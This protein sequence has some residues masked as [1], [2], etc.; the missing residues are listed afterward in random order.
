MSVFI[1]LGLIFA[2]YRQ[3]LERKKQE[4]ALLAE[5]A[6]NADKAGE[7]AGNITVKATAKGLQAATVTI[8][9]K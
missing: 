9:A 6:D 1:S 3:V 5:K 7:K 2:K 8:V 4:E